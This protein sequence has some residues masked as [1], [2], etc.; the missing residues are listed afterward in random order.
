M[1]GSI[2]KAIP[3]MT[4]LFCYCEIP[5]RFAT[6]FSDPAEIALRPVIYTYLSVSTARKMSL[7]I[8][9]SYP[10]M[11]ADVTRRVD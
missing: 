7:L 6:T 8:I 2:T 1:G 3:V 9:S 11:H 5:R 4:H 10:L